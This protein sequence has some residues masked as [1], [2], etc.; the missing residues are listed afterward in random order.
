MSAAERLLD[1]YRK[2]A[3]GLRSRTEKFLKD[4]D[5]DNTHDLRTMIRRFEAIV[6]LLP[7]KLRKRK[8]LRRYLTS[9]RK[10]FRSTTAV[11]DIDIVIENIQG[12]S[13]EPRIRSVISTIQK[14]REALVST[15]LQFANSLHEI[16][17]PRIRQKDLSPKYISKRKD[18]IVIKLLA[19]LREELPIILDDFA[20]VDAM[21]DLRKE[22]KMLRYTLELFP[23]SQDKKLLEMMR[24]WQTILGTVRDIDATQRFAAERKLSEE[25]EET[26][27]RLKTCRDKL[28]ESFSLSA[29]PEQLILTAK[30]R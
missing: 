25:L 16:K 6:D 2:V 13:S 28:I 5:A 3:N 12:S 7:R 23:S 22:C 10:L 19:K 11:R 4:P 8:K 29:I 30:V 24:S 21:H 20:K 27:I 1:N 9:C 18:K 26:L 15:S 17:A 14:E